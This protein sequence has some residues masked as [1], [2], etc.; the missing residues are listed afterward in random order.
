MNLYIDFFSALPQEGWINYHGGG[1][2]TRSVIQGLSKLN[3][4]DLNIVLLC[5]KGFIM[6]KEN[7]PELYNLHNVSYITIKHTSY[8]PNFRNGDIIFYPMLGYLHELKEIATIKRRCPGVKL[9]ATLH[10]IRFMEY[11]PDRTEKYYKNGL[12][13]YVFPIYNF[14]VNVAL[15]KV[16]KGLALKR[17]LKSL[18]EVYTVSNYSMQSILKYNKRIKISWYYQT[19]YSSKRIVSERIINE[20][21]ILFLSGARP[22]KN[23]AHA[24]I[25]FSIYKKD[26]MFNR[27]KL[28]ITGINQKQLF[29]L[30]D[31]PGVDKKLIKENTIV[32]GYVSNE[33]LASLYANSR[34]VLYTSRNE[35]FGLPI[36]EAALYGKTCIASNITSIP[37]VLS[38]AVR[39]VNPTDDADIAK[40][41]EFLCDDAHLKQYENRIVESSWLLKQRMKLEQR[42]FFEDLL[43]V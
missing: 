29:N 26:N 6:S 7:E 17:C 25:G 34:F 14:A 40:E 39:Y 22:I 3:K 27:I 23:L 13:R 20:E 11:I 42:Y 33:Q 4:E 2:Y 12:K 35:G 1:N 8:F 18:D 10:D 21:Y 41:I 31:I 16:I 24:L 37:E 38:S 15:K 19:I 28:V 43:R 5:P 30:C 32:I 9:C 36:L